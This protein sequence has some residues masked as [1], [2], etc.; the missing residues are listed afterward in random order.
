M[1]RFTDRFFF[2]GDEVG[3]VTVGV[4]WGR[5]CELHGIRLG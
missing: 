4:E 1:H 2:R 5:D 3:F